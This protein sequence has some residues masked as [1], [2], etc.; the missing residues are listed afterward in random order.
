M[1]QAISGRGE[2]SHDHRRVR[3][4]GRMARSI[5]RAFLIEGEFLYASE[6]VVV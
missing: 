1:G 5:L 4:K 3:V 2:V 6:S